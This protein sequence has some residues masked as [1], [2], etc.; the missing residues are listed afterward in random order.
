V[1]GVWRGEGEDLSISSDE[2]A[3]RS[4]V[5][6]AGYYAGIK[7]HIVDILGLTDPFF[8]RLPAIERIANGHYM[9]A[10]SWPEYRKRLYDHS[11][12]FTDPKLNSYYRQI[13]SIT[14]SDRLFTLPRLRAIVSLNNGSSDGLL[15]EYRQLVTAKQR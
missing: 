6:C 13:E 3:F 8:A 12:E 5:G 14:R 2:I 9:R 4:A 10:F 11:S 1:L 7:P 15:R